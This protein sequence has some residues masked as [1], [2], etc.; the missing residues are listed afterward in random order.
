MSILSK[1][2]KSNSERG[3]KFSLKTHVKNF[4]NNKHLLKKIAFQLYAKNITYV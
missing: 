2:K 3:V 4:T 1:K